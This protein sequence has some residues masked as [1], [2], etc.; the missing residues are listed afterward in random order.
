M[1]SQSR[2][3]HLTRQD[4]VDIL[5]LIKA[6]GLA[7]DDRLRKE[8]N[9]VA[10]YGRVEISCVERHRNKQ[11]EEMVYSDIPSKTHR[12]LAWDYLSPGRGVV[13]KTFEVTLRL[14]LDLIS[15]RPKIVW[16]HN[17]EM[18]ILVFFALLLRKMNFIEKVVWDFHEFP[19]PLLMK[20]SL[21]KWILKMALLRVDS[22]IVTNPERDEYLRAELGIEMKIQSEKTFYIENFPDAV[23]RDY[24]FTPL[25]NEVNSWLDGAPYL[26]AQGG[27]RDD[28]FHHQMIAAC[29]SAG[30]KLIV[31]GQVQGERAQSRMVYYTGQIPQFD[32][33]PFIDHCLASVVLYE[34]KSPNTRFCSPNRLY[35][36]LMRGKPVLV[37]N[38]PPMRKLIERTNAGVVLNTDGRDAGDLQEGI[39]ILINGIDEFTSQAIKVKTHYLWENHEENFRKIV[40]LPSSRF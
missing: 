36:A 32:I 38:N 12:V 37:G 23:L 33:V 39:T 22:L 30:V 2:S 10:K 25:A 9:S 6:D 24:P 31:I 14:S 16:V 3:N 29:E 4:R 7:Y 1:A 34:N 11:I 35:Q 17:P 21:S 20:S 40:T 19:S 26:L 15:R 13:F 5:M 18:I 28:R 27:G 8:C